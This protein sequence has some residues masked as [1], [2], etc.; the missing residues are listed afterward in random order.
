MMDRQLSHM[1]RL[2]DDL[3]DVS[4]ISRGVLELKRTS[5]ELGA[6]I[7]HALEMSRPFL[8]QR[9]QTVAIEIQSSVP[10]LIDA[11][12]VTQIVGNL[13]H[14]ASKYTPAG[15]RIR[16]ELAATGGAATIR[17]IDAGAGIPLGQLDRV[18]DMFARIERT[19][20]H[21]SGGLGI[22]LSLA[23]RLAELHGGT[24]TASSA[25]EGQG[26][27]F[28]LTLPAGGAAA[29]SPAPSAAHPA[30]AP[31]AAAPA[32]APLALLDIVVVE[33]NDDAADTLSLWLGEMGHRVRVARTGPEGLDLVREIRPDVVL[34]DL[35]LPDMDGVEVCRRI[36]ELA[37]ESHPLLVA[38]TGWGM[39]DD[40]RRTAAVGFEHHLVKPLDP[41]QLRAILQ[42]A[43]AARRARSPLSA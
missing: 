2:I 21:V 11:T 36:K 27:T 13:L 30:G 32:A 19:G 5:T 18:F 31:P 3:L 35:G 24:L 1:V 42:S 28:T 22:G 16:V 7:D 41:D 25:G 43:A 14:N 9:R 4:R 37:L 23:R 17:V 15:G 26:A 6:V 12:R 10:A 8:D 38:V 20:P 34:C 39:E 33:D 29:A 40:R